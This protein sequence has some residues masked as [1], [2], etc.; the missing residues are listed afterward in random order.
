MVLPL[1]NKNKRVFFF[2]V[3]F[4]LSPFVRFVRFGCFSTTV[5]LVWASVV[6]L[7]LLF[8]KK[9]FD[10]T[11]ETATTARLPLAAV[12]LCMCRKTTAGGTDKVAKRTGIHSIHFFDLFDRSHLPV[13]VAVVVMFAAANEMRFDVRSVPTNAG[14][15]R[16]T[17]R[18]LVF[19]KTT[20]GGTN[21]ITGRTLVRF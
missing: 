13:L 16:A 14:L 12:G 19:V 17:V 4:V 2:L 15:I 18:H 6:L 10:V 20:T 7:G 5:H 9:T 1:L 3:P 21:E 11:G 8:V